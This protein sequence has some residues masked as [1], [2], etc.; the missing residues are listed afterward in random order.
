MLDSFPFFPPVFI[1]MTWFP[2]FL[3]SDRLVIIAFNFVLV[4]ISMNAYFIILDIF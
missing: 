4:L 1:L 3:Q 2:S